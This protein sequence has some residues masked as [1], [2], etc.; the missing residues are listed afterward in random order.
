MQGAGT[1]KQPSAASD[2]RDT[3][4]ITPYQ[5]TDEVSMSRR[6]V[7]R[8]VLLRIIVLA[9]FSLGLPL[10]LAAEPSE[11]E[12]SPSLY[13]TPRTVQGRLA[14]G[15]RVT[16]LDVREPDEFAAGHL[17]G[18]LNIA[19]DR[20]ASLIDRLPHDQPV[21]VYCIHSTHRAPEA[22]KTLRAHGMANAVVLEGGIVAW[23]A[24][25]AMIL[26]SDTTRSPTILPL[27]ERCADKG[28]PPS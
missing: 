21:V 8:R 28:K 12:A 15:Q 5:R 2:S 4:L 17:P 18:A 25:G 10:S 20:V 26:A 22:V 23:E 3:T 9:L 24:G 11:S 6:R 13:V 16:F 1:C 19:H 27:T 7:G 14:Q